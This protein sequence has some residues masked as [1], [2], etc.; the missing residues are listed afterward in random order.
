MI[1]LTPEVMTEKK[2]WT[3]DVEE[4]NDTI[5]LYVAPHDVTVY[6]AT[7]LDAIA[8]LADT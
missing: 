2:L 8:P 1:Q 5:S 6:E 3:S 7:D 4:G